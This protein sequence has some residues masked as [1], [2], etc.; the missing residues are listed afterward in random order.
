MNTLL[1]TLGVVAVLLSVSA[2]A[3]DGSAKAGKAVFNKNCAVCH[4]ETGKGDGVAAAGLN[5]R[6]ANF[7]EAARSSTPREKQVRI[8]TNGG[9]SEKLSPLMPAFGEMLSDQQIADVVSYVREVIQAPGG[10]V[11]KN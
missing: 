10:A 1:R 11:A 4:G 9:A 5:P 6:P 2:F 8:V 3:G 7:L